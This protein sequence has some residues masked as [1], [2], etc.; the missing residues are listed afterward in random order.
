MYIM[1]KKSATILVLITALIS[2]I[3]NFVNKIAVTA[4]KDP[5]L[6]TTLKN[7]LVALALLAFM[8]WAGQWSC[9]RTVSKKQILLLAAVGIIGGSVPFALYF[10]GLTMTSATNA[11][12]IHKTLFLWVLIFAYP[13]LKE[14]MT[15][16]QL[17][18]VAAIFAANTLVG[19]FNGFKFN[20]GELMILAAAILWG[21]ESI[22][23]KKALAELPSAT[24]AA[25]RMAI[26]AVILTAIVAYTGGFSKLALIGAAN[27]GWIALTSA[28]LLGYVG[29]WYAGLKRA[30][31][32]YVAALLVPATLVTNALSAIFVTHAFGIYDLVNALLFGAGIALVILFAKKSTEQA[33]ATPILNPIS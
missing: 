2:G 30:P 31:A 14:R 17:F 6:Y 7:A 3:S 1:N 12:L 27:W 11:A 33:N 13:I 10:T 19:G 32:T 21:L 25:A 4:V 20:S 29:T 9:L 15:A 22:F 26:G 16:P 5:M 23:A 8:T 24:V 28:L 18:G